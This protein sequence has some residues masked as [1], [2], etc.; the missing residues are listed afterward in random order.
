MLGELSME[1]FVMGGGENFHEGS[2]KFSSIIKKKNEKINMK[3]FF[4]QLKVRTSIKT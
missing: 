1:E 3:K 2:A 4:F